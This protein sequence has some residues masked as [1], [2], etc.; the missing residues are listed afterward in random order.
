MTYSVTKEFTF[1]AAHHLTGLPTSH[2]CSRVHGHNYIVKVLIETDT[3][4][5]TGFVIDYGQLDWIKRLIDTEY[6]HRSLNSVVNF[7]PTAELLAKHFHGKVLKW[8]DDE[9][10]GRIFF[11]VVAISETAKTWATYTNVDYVEGDLSD[12]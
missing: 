9:F 3:L 5:A 6:D 1:S 10:N 2:P 7:N 12:V 11:V 8:L 4:D